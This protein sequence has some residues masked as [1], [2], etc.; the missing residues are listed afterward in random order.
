MLY[1][2]S[3][4]YIEF[5]GEDSYEEG[6]IKSLTHFNTLE[7]DF[8]STSLALVKEV[9]IESLLKKGYTDKDIDISLNSC[10]KLGRIDITFKSTKE[11]SYRLPDDKSLKA[12]EKGEINLYNITL[13]FNVYT[14]IDCGKTYNQ[15]F[16][17]DC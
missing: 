2:L 13:C 17:E 15:L 11:K 3:K 7:N 16:L 10:E 14:S 1:K 6:E 8:Y 9:I 4:Y 12:F 5:V